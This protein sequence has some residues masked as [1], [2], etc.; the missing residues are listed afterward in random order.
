MSSQHEISEY[1]DNLS[2]QKRFCKGFRPDDVYDV[3]CNI[4]S[5]YN[6]LLAESYAE[7]DELKSE[8][9]NAELEKKAM[10]AQL[11]C[12]TETTV[13]EANP[14]EAFEEV[15]AEKDK[16][17]ERLNKKLQERR[18]EIEKAGTIAE[19][20]FKLNGVYEATEKAAKQYLENLQALYE[21]EKDLHARKE[22]EVQT[23]CSVLLHAAYERCQF[24]KEE[25][26]KNCK[27]ME[28]AAK[29]KCEDL[30]NATQIQCDEREKA[31]AERCLALDQKA[32]KAVDQ[33]WDE[34]SRRL[35][36]FYT[37]HEGLRELLAIGGEKQSN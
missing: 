3:I 27:D 33:R 14:E 17:I 15:L 36:D 20:S 21:K 35:E 25:T 22:T 12:R 9:E 31:A 24:M 37:A 32:K 6:Q 8:L 10:E 29:K 5:M 26:E 34:L 7:N 19:A 1:I 30:W 23:K 13:N 28:T 16:E 11:N 2:L 4:S 18:I